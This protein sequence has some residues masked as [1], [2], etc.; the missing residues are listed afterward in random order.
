MKNT[1]E[2]ILAHGRNSRK[3]DVLYMVGEKVGWGNFLFI[4]EIKMNEKV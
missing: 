3:E 2:I 1:E 4:F